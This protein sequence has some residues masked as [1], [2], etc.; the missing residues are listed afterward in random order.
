MG[1]TQPVWWD[2][3]KWN[4]PEYPVV[5]I[6]WYEAWAYAHWAGRRL[7]TEAE[8]EKAASAEPRLGSSSRSELQAAKRTYPWGNE[9]DG[10]KCNVRTSKLF[11]DASG[12]TTPVGQYSPV[13]DS[14]Y[15]CVDMAGNV[16]EWTSSLYRPYPY[17]ADDGREDVE[18]Q[19]DRVVRGGSFD[20]S[21]DAARCAYRDHGSPNAR[22]RS[23]GFRVGVGVVAAPFSPT[24]EL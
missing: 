22:Y 16:W 8:W 21:A 18:A 20:G 3:E 4:R 14:P 2:D 19:G 7:L 17:Q 9:F 24:S 12:A 13:G 5:G 11:A 10:E 23:N 6:A 1:R 15:G